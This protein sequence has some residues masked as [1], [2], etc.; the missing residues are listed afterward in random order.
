MADSFAVAIMTETVTNGVMDLKLII[1]D[2]DNRHEAVGRGFD[3]FQDVGII[4]HKVT[5]IRIGRAN[6][7]SG[8]DQVYLD[9]LAEGKKIHAIKQCRTDTGMGLIDAKKYIENLESKHNIV[10]DRQVPYN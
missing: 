9:F 3:R 6:A 4:V 1:I 5:S 7:A 2:A 8:A 10:R